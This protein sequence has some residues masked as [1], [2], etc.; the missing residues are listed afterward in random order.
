MVEADPIKD[1]L[2]SSRRI[3]QEGC[4]HDQISTAQ[5]TLI[6]LQN[7]DRPI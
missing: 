2:D 4:L 1:E 7:N 3:Y 5:K 6:G